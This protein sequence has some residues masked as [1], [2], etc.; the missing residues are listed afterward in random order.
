MGVSL[1]LVGDVSLLEGNTPRLINSF[2]SSGVNII[3]EDRGLT[4]QPLCR[5]HALAAATI[6]ASPRK[7]LAFR[8]LGCGYGSKNSPWLYLFGLH[9]GYIF[10]THSQVGSW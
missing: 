9:L 10:L 3:G 1:V 6:Q 8:R 2:F 4:G 5:S 7:L